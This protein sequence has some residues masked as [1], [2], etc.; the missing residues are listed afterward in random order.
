MYCFTVYDFMLALWR[1]IG[2]VIQFTP[3]MECAACF[4][5]PSLMLYWQDNLV[6]KLNILLMFGSRVEVR[7]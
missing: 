6:F 4:V 5:L 7:S 3:G 2:S 1:T